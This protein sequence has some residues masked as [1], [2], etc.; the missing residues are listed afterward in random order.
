MKTSAGLYLGVVLIGSMGIAMASEAERGLGVAREKVPPAAA[1]ALDRAGA[2]ARQH[3]PARLTGLARAE[4]VLVEAL[5]K[6]APQARGGLERAL[7]EVRSMQRALNDG[8]Q[9]VERLA[10]APNAAGLNK[11]IA[12]V[13]RGTQT[14][15]TRLQAILQQVPQEARFAIETALV[16]SRKGR[17]ESLAALGAIREQNPA[18]SGTAGSTER[19]P[20]TAASDSAR[21][22]GPP[23]GVGGGRAGG[24]GRPGR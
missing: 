1:P 7:Q 10:T 8:R 6:A 3:E 18:A 24:G 16:E 2:A 11:A 13:D 14:H 4:Q 22:G 19:K 9:K 12:E 20:P 15:L 21:P 17:E 5:E 23:A